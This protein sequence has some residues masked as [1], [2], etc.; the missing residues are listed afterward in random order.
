MS[1]RVGPEAAKNHVMKVKILWT[2]LTRHKQETHLDLSIFTDRCLFCDHVIDLEDN[3]HKLLRDIEHG[4]IKSY[5]P[6]HGLHAG[7]T[8]LTYDDQE[9]D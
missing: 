4:K 2:D 1:G 6:K 9:G 5:V 3:P 7:D 8:I